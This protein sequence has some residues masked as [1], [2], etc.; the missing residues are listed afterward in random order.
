MK[1]SPLTLLLILNCGNAIAGG[2]SFPARVLS[3]SLHAEKE[4]ILTFTQTPKHGAFADCSEI[5]VTV[6]H[7]RAP[8]FSW[9]PF[10][11]SSHP[12]HAETATALDFLS[13]AMESGVLVQFG[14]VGSGVEPG[15]ASCSFQSRGL[16]LVP[17]GEVKY[18]LSYFDAV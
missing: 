5:E 7:K 18:V 10:V 14:Y 15:S 12:S 8:W 16:R 6:A 11:R 17:D 3:V 13:S 1:N 4:L 2:S 9:I